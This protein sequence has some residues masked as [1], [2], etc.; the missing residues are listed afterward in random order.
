MQF[1]LNGLGLPKKWQPFLRLGTTTFG[2]YWVRYSGNIIDLALR[3]RI[4]TYFLS[5]YYNNLSGTVGI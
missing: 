1:I 2:T 3:I 5:N 4:R